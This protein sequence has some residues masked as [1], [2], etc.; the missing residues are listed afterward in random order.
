MCH[1]DTSRPPSAPQAGDCVDHGPVVLTSADGAEVSAYLAHPAAPSGRGVVILPDVRGLHPYYEQLAVRFAEAGFHAVAVDFYGRTLG[2]APHAEDV[3]WFAEV[4]RVRPEEVVIDARA[5]V[6]HLSERGARAV[7]SVGFCFGGSQ[8]WRLSATDLGLAGCIGFYGR[9]ALVA[10]VEPG[11]SAPLLLLV[12]GADRATP[13]AEF[14]AFSQRLRAR[15]Q[16]HRMV[17]YPGAPHSFFDRAFDQW[18]DACTD[19]WG[20]VL[21]FAEE[22]DPGSA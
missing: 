13:L 12:A 20:Q 11:L 22:H 6:T 16:E 3:D 21:T 7:F 2:L 5:A 19:A 4:A 1:D 8:S 10:D 15:G 18:Q 9:P 17:V 14:E